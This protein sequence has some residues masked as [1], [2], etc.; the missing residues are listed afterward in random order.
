MNLR[1]WAAVPRGGVYALENNIAPRVFRLATFEESNA[2]WERFFIDAPIDPP[3][4]PKYSEKDGYYLEFTCGTDKYWV[5]QTR[6]VAA[7][8][9]IGVLEMRS[10]Y[11]AHWFEIIDRHHILSVLE[12]IRVDLLG[13]LDAIAIK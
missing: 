4:E 13:W 8:I 12:L 11:S 10:P 2:G 6:A 5:R 7:S 1:E 3:G 9:R